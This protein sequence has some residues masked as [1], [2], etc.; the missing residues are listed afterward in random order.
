ML[1]RI[2][3]TAGISVTTGFGLYSLKKTNELNLK[4][5]KLEVENSHLKKDLDSSNKLKEQRTEELW[6]A[7][8]LLNM[9]NEPKVY[10]EIIKIRKSIT[11]LNTFNAFLIS[12]EIYDYLKL[13]PKDRL[14]TKEDY[15]RLEKLY[16][17]RGKKANS[18]KERTAFNR[19]IAKMLDNL[20]FIKWT[21]PEYKNCFSTDNCYLYSR[22]YNS[23]PYFTKDDSAC[24]QGLHLTYLS[25]DSWI[26]S[27]YKKGVG[28]AKIVPIQGS[29]ISMVVS[30]GKIRTA[31]LNMVKLFSIP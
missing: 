13:Y 4:I 21:N 17:E 14:A 30:D 2:A 19:D 3:F 6:K 28:L 29:D 24:S 23:H 25:E 16:N 20:I 7:L 18:P 31:A 11:S 27:F 1:S 22:G 10:K 5:D 8:V 26:K 12:R 9:F 15:A